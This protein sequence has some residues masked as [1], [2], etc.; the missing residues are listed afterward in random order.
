[1]IAINNLSI[2]FSKSQILHNLSLTLEEGKI[3]SLIGPSGCGKSTLL[4][5]FC[6]ILSNYNGDIT[7]NG[8]SIAKKPISIGYVP[9]SYGLL[10]WKTVEKNITLPHQI[11]P[12]LTIGKGEFN[13]ILN[14]LEIA[15]L[16]KRYPSE[17]SGG[18][19]QRV[20]LARAFATK[21]CL[22][23]MDEPFSALDAFTSAAAQKLFLK[24]WAKH[25]TTTLFITHNVYEALETSQRIILMDKAGNI[26]EVLDNPAFANDDEQT[27]IELR[28][29]IIQKLGQNI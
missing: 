5:I 25:K 10:D 3:Y 28:Q 22:L 13:E 15:H 1:M 27:R 8:E 21:P 17:I 11:H 16:L 2:S 12:C 18:Q 23:L 29:T 6:G 14:E 19:K 4:K 20:A 9:Q 24:L 26:I 7:Y